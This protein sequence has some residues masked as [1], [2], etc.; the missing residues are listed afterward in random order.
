MGAKE[1][2]EK[3]LGTFPQLRKSFD[4]V[5][6]WQEGIETGSIIVFEDVYFKYLKRYLNNENISNKNFEFIKS[7]LDSNDDYAINV[8]SVAIIENLIA[9]TK[10]ELYVKYF[11]DNMKKIANE[12]GKEYFYNWVNIK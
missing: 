3:L 12:I 7:L 1:L 2:N 10:R 4:N 9:T 5:T 8:V 6:S 11:D